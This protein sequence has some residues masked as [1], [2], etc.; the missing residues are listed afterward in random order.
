M[1]SRDGIHVEYKRDVDAR[2]IPNVS[3]VVSNMALRYE[4]STCMDMLGY[5]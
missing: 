3:C 2:N 1:G 5:L 4:Q